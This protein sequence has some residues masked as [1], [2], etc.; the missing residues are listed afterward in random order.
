M[1][2]EIDQ[3]QQ[4]SIMLKAQL[5]IVIKLPGEKAFDYAEKICRWIAVVE[6]RLVEHGLPI[7]SSAQSVPA[8]AYASTSS[9]LSVEHT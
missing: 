4:T 3:L 5:E 7:A 2:S 6:A 9:L 8:T 1:I